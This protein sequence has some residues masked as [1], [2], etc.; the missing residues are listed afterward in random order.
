MTDMRPVVVVGSGVAGLS[1]ALALAPLPVLLLTS[2]ALGAQAATPWAQGGLAAAVGPDDAPEAHAADTIAAGAELCD[3]AVVA[4]VTNAAPA[5]ARELTAL[6][7]RFARNADGTLALGREGGHGVH[8]I[9]HA[10]DATGAEIERVLVAATRACEAIVVR[11]GVRAER[12]VQAADGAICG[13]ETCDARGERARIEARAVILATGGCG[14]LYART[15]NPL[16]SYGSGLALAARA[17][18]RL[19]D[20]EFVQFHPTALVDSGDPCALVTE[21]LRGA[22]AVLLDA[23]GAPTVT[24]HLPHGDLSPR[25]AV[26][27]AIFAR[28]RR[29]ERVALDAR[30]LGDAFA[31]RFPTVFASCLRI[32]VDPRTTPIPVAPAAHYHMGGIAVDVNGRTSLPGLYACGEVAS[33][34]LHGGNRLAS[35]S[36]LEGL[37]FGARVARDVAASAPARRRR[38]RAEPTTIVRGEAADRLRLRETMYR[39]VGLVRNA[40]GLARA[41]ATCETVWTC[42]A[43][44]AGATGRDAAHPRTTGELADRV[45]LGTLIARAAAAREETRGGHARAEFPDASAPARRSFVQL[46]PADAA[47]ESGAALAS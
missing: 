39:D 15:T 3:A 20:L 40:A 30:M 19:A 16:G 37:V 8:R 34:G 23:T 14:A 17:G 33:T 26:A 31:E 25:D 28:V 7:A 27:R 35:N 21:A 2:A 6:G 42:A 5:V 46:P 29:G 10:A 41:I 1:A 4:L 9:V 24:A 43:S 11:E 18:A 38:M 45:L 22:G 13:L 44:R 36:L 47:A 12:L 32:G